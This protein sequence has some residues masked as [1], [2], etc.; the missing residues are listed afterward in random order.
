MTERFYRKVRY[1]MPMAPRYLIC[2]EESWSGPTGAVEP[3]R[4][5]LLQRLGGRT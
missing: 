3:T 5:L 4:L 1:L 2:T